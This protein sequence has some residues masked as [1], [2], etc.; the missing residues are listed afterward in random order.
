MQRRGCDRCFL[1]HRSDNL[2]CYG[3]TRART[4]RYRPRQIYS[5][6]TG[7]VMPWRVVRVDSQNRAWLATRRI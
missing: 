3:N 1:Y 6:S 4:R 7:E 2:A 5:V